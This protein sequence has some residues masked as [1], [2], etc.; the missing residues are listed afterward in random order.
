MGRRLRAWRLRL[1]GLRFG[2]QLVVQIEIIGAHTG[3]YFGNA[4]AEG[5]VTI[6]VR[7]VAWAARV[8]EAAVGAVFQYVFLIACGQPACIAFDDRLDGVR[9]QPARCQCAVVVPRIPLGG[10]GLRLFRA[11]EARLAVVGVIPGFDMVLQGHTMPFL[12]YQ[13]VRAIVLMLS[14]YQLAF[15]VQ[16]QVACLPV[17]EPRLQL[18]AVAVL[19]TRLRRCALDD[20]V[21]AAL[22]VVPGDCPQSPVLVP[23]VVQGAAFG[24]P[25]PD[26]AVVVIVAELLGIA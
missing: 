3:R 8:C 26:Q 10:F 5:I 1:R 15:V 7:R 20:S 21:G 25:M 13:A 2:Y 23:L 4:L 24:Q 6:G 11:Y 19:V 12:L 14:P 22:R 18:Q 17:G 9:C 16:D